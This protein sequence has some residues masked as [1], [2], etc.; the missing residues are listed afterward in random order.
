MCASS[1]LEAAY[2]SG[3]RRAQ[4]NWLAN[5][6]ACL[7]MLVSDPVRISKTRA[8]HLSVV[9]DQKHRLASPAARVQQQCDDLACVLVI[10]VA[11][12]LVSQDQCRVIG[13]SQH[14]AGHRRSVP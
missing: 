6:A 8:D 3:G 9:S 14:A 10:K 2:Q 12:R 1:L 4:V 7:S 5:G 11:D 13:R